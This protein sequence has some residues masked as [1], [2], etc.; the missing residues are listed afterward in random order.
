MISVASKRK[1]EID[2]DYSI[3][4]S[5]RCRVLCEERKVVCRCGQGWWGQCEII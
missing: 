3:I 4:S 1:I 5:G 2:N